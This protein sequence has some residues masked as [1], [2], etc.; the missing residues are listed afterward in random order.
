MRCARPVGLKGVCELKTRE[1]RAVRQAAGWNSVRS[2]TRRRMVFPLALLLVSHPTAAQVENLQ[3]S[4]PAQCSACQIALRHVETIG[5][6]DDEFLY[7]QLSYL[8]RGPGPAYFVANSFTPGVVLV[9]GATGKFDKTIGRLGKGPGEIGE[10]SLI[11]VTPQDSLYVSSNGRVTVFSVPTGAAA[12]S[13][14]PGVGIW[15]LA[16]LGSGIVAGALAPNVR[17]ETV[18]IFDRDGLHRASIS[19]DGPFEHH[20]QLAQKVHVAGD[21]L[22]LVS[23]AGRYQ[24]RAFDASG[25]L[26]WTVEREVDWFK[27]YVRQP[28]GAVFLTPSLPAIVGAWI[29]SNRYLW[30]LLERSPVDWQAPEPPLLPGRMEFNTLLGSHLEVI[31]LQRGQVL[32]SRRLQ[33][34]RPAGQGQPFLYTTRQ[35]ATGHVVFDVWRATLTHP[36]TGHG[37]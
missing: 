32:A 23:A 12:R 22:L 17:Q 16:G 10:R 33:W 14:N 8:V 30:V 24:I 21:S 9:Y 20:D 4:G 34:F 6:N 13:W 11:H 1:K 29:E 35:A 3:V 31:D 18:R 19:F 27:P 7:G 26:R 28:R 25:G 2:C 5:N 15:G 37:Q 36:S